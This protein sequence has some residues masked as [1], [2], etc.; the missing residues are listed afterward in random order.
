MSKKPPYRV[1]PHTPG[2]RVP[3]PKASRPSGF[4][5]DAP[6]CTCIPREGLHQTHCPLYDFRCGCN[7][8]YACYWHRDATDTEESK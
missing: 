6:V 1:K 7:G 3:D 8:T 2:F 4:A 5:G